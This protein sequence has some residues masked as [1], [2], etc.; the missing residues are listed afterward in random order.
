MEIINL[1][2]ILQKRGRR[3]EELQE[4]LSEHD[5]AGGF[6]YLVSQHRITVLGGAERTSEPEIFGT[7][8]KPKY[9]T[10]TE[11]KKI[12]TYLKHQGYQQPIK[13]I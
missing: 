10:T 3:R 6:T 13:F 7:P 2:E 12:R 5:V 8:I 9:F 1:Q 4:L 11:M